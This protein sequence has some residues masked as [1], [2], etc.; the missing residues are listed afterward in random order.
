MAP[1]PG[2]NQQVII[3]TAAGI[4]AHVCTPLQGDYGWIPAAVFHLHQISVP[5]APE[6]G[7]SNDAQVNH[8]LIGGTTSGRHLA[9]TPRNPRPSGRATTPP[10]LIRIAGNVACS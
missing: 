6:V 10:I 8:S 7:E 9:Q 5:H 3:I 1:P 4:E 2:T